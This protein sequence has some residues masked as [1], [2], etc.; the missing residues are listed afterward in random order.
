[1]SDTHKPNITHTALQS[2]NHSDWLCAQLARDHSTHI[3]GSLQDVLGDLHDARVSQLSW[4]TH[5]GIGSGHGIGQLLDGNDDDS[6]WDHC[7]GT[8]TLTST[9]WLD[10]IYIILDG[11]VSVGLQSS[12][13]VRG[14]AGLCANTEMNNTLCFKSMITYIFMIYS[15]LSPNQ[16]S[17][18]IQLHS[19]TSCHQPK[20][21]EKNKLEE[22]FLEIWAIVV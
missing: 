11:S 4:H 7:N 5:P 8:E 17:I 14:L 3:E 12:I 13:Y 6:V 1:M 22:E 9:R 19:S 2:A 10:T 20:N 21:S 16:P 18:Y 15:H